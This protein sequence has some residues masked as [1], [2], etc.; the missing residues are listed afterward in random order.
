[1]SASPHS[2]RALDAIADFKRIYSMDVEGHE[3]DNP[4]PL[5][6]ASEPSPVPSD[7][8]DY[9]HR[10]RKCPAPERATSRS[11]TSRLPL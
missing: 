4:N 3:L 11:P 7:G 6:A 8:P 9:G 1:M 5:T 2:R 10:Y